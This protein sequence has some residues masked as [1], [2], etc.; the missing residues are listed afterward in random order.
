[1]KT[2]AGLIFAILFAVGLVW[3]L[4]A[5]L[6]LIFTDPEYAK[7]SETIWGQLQLIKVAWPGLL[8]M[9]VGGGGW[10]LSEPP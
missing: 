9:I 4:I 5:D 6:K 1:M 8:L 3:T 2:A 7:H 10:Y